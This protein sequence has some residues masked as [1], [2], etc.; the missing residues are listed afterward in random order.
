[1]VHLPDDAA[2]GDAGSDDTASSHDRERA[3]QEEIGRLRAQNEALE[4]SVVALTAQLAGFTQHDSMSASAPPVI[5][6]RAPTTAPPTVP[7]TVLPTVPPLSVPSRTASASAPVTTGDAERFIGR[8]IVP[9]VG[10]LAVMG[11]VGFLVYYAIDV[12]LW[13]AMPPIVRFGVGLAIGVLF[14]ALG[15]FLRRKAPGT[16]VGLDAAGIGAFLITIAIGVHA[17]RLFDVE[18]GA[19]LTGGAGL[20]GAAWSVRTRSATVG[21][22]AFLGL[23]LA[24]FLYNIAQ[25]SPL[26]SGLLF[27]L[28]IAVGLV[29]HALADE[30]SRARFEVL[31]FCALFAAL[32]GGLVLIGRELFSRRAN[33]TDATEVGFV[34]LW[35]GA[36]VGSTALHAVRGHGRVANLVIIAA[37]SLG[38][39]LVQLGTWGATA[40]GDLRAWFPSLAGGILATTG[41]FLRSFIT[42]SEHGFDAPT[43]GDQ[44]PSRATVRDAHEGVDLTSEA[45]SG[46]SNAAVALGLAMFFGGFV[47]FAPSGGQPLSIAAIAVGLT[48]AAHRT[49]ALAFDALGVFVAFVAAIFAWFYA[50]VNSFNATR[51]VW[52]LPLGTEVTVRWSW[53]FIAVLVACIALFAQGTLRVRTATDVLRIGVACFAWMAPACTF[54]EG[55]PFAGALAIPAA[56][57]AFVSNARRAMIVGALGLLVFALVLWSTVLFGM[58]GNAL[59]AWGQF[60]VSLYA[61]VL[62]TVALVG[63]GVHRALGGARALVAPSSILLS[64]FT[65]AALGVSAGELAGVAAVDLTLLFVL[66]VASIGALLMAV[67]PLLSERY[68]SESLVAGAMAAVVAL[69]VA[70]IHGLGVLVESRT[71]Q[72]PE[73]LLAFLACAAVAAAASCMRW[74]HGRQPDFF[75]A[76]E[77]AVLGLFA[78]AAVP[79][80]ALLLASVFPEGIA[81]GVGAVCVAAWVVSVGVG[82][83]AIGFLRR[84]AALRWG[85]LVAFVF[86]VLRLFLVDLAGAPTLVR[87]A[88]LFVTGLALVGV[89]VVYARFGRSNALGEGDDSGRIAP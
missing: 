67:L 79:L 12:G 26:L 78:A 16:S 27:T 70:S 28:S 56:C 81:S 33:P 42:P 55:F 63:C 24:P 34:L 52:E 74:T 6:Q 88:L 19:L 25:E 75:K 15:E 80:G 1:M 48:I 30:S 85:G 69:L 7:P 40:T 68:A 50:L 51:V 13:G 5:A 36:F 10:A 65:L 31:R 83:I 14:L 37:A 62:L 45:C 9:I 18:I 20:F 35:F 41:F 17:L 43:H 46:L 39:F 66:I 60:E 87:V 49:R 76:A 29:M 32:V 3:L 71:A 38:A 23:F 53:S 11:A 64:V 84:I 82:E 21:V 73:T 77:G 8:W 54:V 72:P 59:G 58:F 86:L 22:C 4:R 2:S 57:L 47:H 61:W 44:S 89:S